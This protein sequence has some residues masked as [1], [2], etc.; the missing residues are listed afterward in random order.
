[1]KYTTYFLTLSIFLT[2]CNKTI[3]DSENN[4]GG[5]TDINAINFNDSADF[6]NQSCQYAIINEYE[7]SYYPSE[8]PNSSIP[9]IDSWDIPGTGADADLKLTI[10]ESDSNNYFFSS[11]I[12]DNQSPNSPAY[13]TASV[14]EKLLSTTYH[15]E[16]YDHDATNSNEF[17]DSGSFNPIN[18]AVNG[19]ITIYGKNPPINRTQIVLHYV[20]GN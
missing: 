6:E 12:I 14:N 18:K 3:F 19:K 10:I 2:S 9:F 11:P 5:C 13:W 15:W 7:V 17:I 16:L 4:L 20:L 8:N 1:M